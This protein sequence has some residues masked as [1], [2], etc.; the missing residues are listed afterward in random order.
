MKYCF[1]AS[2][3]NLRFDKP[4]GKGWELAGPLR[5][6]NSKSIA[7]RLIRSELRIGMGAL[8]VAPFLEGKPYVYAVGEYPLEDDSPEGQAKVIYHHLNTIQTLF[9]MFWLVKDNSMNFTMGF[10]EYPYSE[11]SGPSM[12]ARVSSSS[13]GINFTNADGKRS[14]TVFNQSDLMF[15]LQLY[16]GMF[17]WEFDD[18]LVKVKDPGP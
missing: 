6:T 1:L 4:M 9:Q 10:L 11:T 12:N 18:L 2:L 13:K 17:A 16:Q 8:E 5:I 15:A 14:E 7:N 3:D